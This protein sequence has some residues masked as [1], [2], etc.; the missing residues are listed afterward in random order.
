[1]QRNYR[2]NWPLQ[3]VVGTKR[4]IYHMIFSGQDADLTLAKR[5]TGTAL[6]VTYVASFHRSTEHVA[7]FFCCNEY[8]VKKC[9]FSK[10]EH[11]KDF[12]PLTKII[13]L[14]IYFRQELQNIKIL[15]LC[16]VLFFFYLQH[17]MLAFTYENKDNYVECHFWI[18][19]RE[20]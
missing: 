13:F 5:D 16:V 8:S 10:L 9:C 15:I 2:M 12:L 19:G 7:L 20:I 11:Y 3:Q 1:M 6:A 17:F 18:S 4:T 14:M